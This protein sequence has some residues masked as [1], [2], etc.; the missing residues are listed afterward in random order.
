MHRKKKMIDNL[1]QV[2]NAER[3]PHHRPPGGMREDGA[4][5]LAFYF[6]R[7]HFFSSEKRFKHSIF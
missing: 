2:Y 3:V 5:V 1:S 7:D 6:V 4:P